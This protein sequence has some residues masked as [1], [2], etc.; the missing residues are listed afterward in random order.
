MNNR[1]SVPVS[2]PASFGVSQEEV[3]ELADQLRGRSGESRQLRAGNATTP[4]RQ[5]KPAA[6]RS[7]VR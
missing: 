4:S 6:P 5:D 7:R 3:T 1:F 2:K